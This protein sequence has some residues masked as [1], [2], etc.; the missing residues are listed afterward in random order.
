MDVYGKYCYKK[1]QDCQHIKNVENKEIP[2]P[3]DLPELFFATPYTVN[4]F[5]HLIS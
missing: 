4:E 5:Y 1:Y 3:E 2:Y